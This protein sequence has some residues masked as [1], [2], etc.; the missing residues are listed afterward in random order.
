MTAAARSG[1]WMW[2]AVVGAL[3]MLLALGSC[4]STPAFRESDGRPLDGSVAEMTDL[5]LNG[6]PQRIWLRGASMR[7]PLLVLVHGGPGASESPL[8]RAFVPELE[9]HFLVVYWEQRGTGRSFDPTIPPETMRIDQFVADLHA[10]IDAMRTRFDAGP[11]IIVAH[12]WGTAPG[13]L[14]AARHPGDVLAYV[15]VAQTVD[16]LAGERISWQSAL[17]EAER[18]GDTAAIAALRNIGPPPHD[19][20]AMLVS[21]RW[22]ERL[23]GAFHAPDLSTGALIWRAL[24]QSEVGLYDLWL[25]GR[26]NR[27]SLER[28][29]PEF[30]QLRLWHI[31]H[32]DVPVFLIQGRHDRQVPSSLAETWFRA[33]SAPCRRLFWFE[34]SAH[35]PPFEQ[36]AAFVEVIVRH[37]APLAGSG[38]AAATPDLPAGVS[39]QR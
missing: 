35:N 12:S 16:M 25:F 34:D 36:P 28:L 2:L 23:G 19:V 4:T 10:L 22:N 24:Q 29:W 20:D 15:G 11:A 30:S 17:D 27:W 13:L 18:R 7:N 14:H 37:V 31:R 38:C 32:L 33:V 6:V 21:R 8:F 3:T 5:P 26:G 39:V 9:R 1:H